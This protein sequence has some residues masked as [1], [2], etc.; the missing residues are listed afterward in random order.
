MFYTVLV[1]KAFYCNAYDASNYFQRAKVSFYSQMMFLP[2]KKT[3]H[4]KKELCVRGLPPKLSKLFKRKTSLILLM[5]TNF[6]NYITL[7]II[8]LLSLNFKSV[9][10]H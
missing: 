10:R 4:V 8:S 2:L 6:T 9:T 7:P 3:Q 1:V 5:K